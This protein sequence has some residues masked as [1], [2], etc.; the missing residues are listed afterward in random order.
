MFPNRIRL[1][2][3]VVLLVALVIVLNTYS[4][5]REGKLW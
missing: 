4:Q 1:V 2:P 3:R 5:S